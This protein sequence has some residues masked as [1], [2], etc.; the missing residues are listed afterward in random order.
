MSRIAAWWREACVVAAVVL[1]V[2]QFQVVKSDASDA[3]SM[4]QQQTEINAKLTAIVSENDTRL[5]IYLE[6]MGF[7]K[8]DAHD[9]AEMP[10]EAPHDSLGNGIARVPWLRTD[11]AMQV[12]ER[13]QFNDSG[14]VLVDT[15]WDFREKA[16]K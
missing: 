15:L 16:K 8:E 1:V 12:G 4:M 3:K 2:W 6:L 9:W 7:D 13:L 10:R 14:R 5:K 11:S